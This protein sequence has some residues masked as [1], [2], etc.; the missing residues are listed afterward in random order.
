MQT[1]IFKAKLSG[2]FSS[3]DALYVTLWQ[4]WTPNLNICFESLKV[5]IFRRSEAGLQCAFN[6]T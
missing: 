4:I 1:N 5:H 3:L 6:V 2:L